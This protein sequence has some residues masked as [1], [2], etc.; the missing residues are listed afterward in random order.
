M[1]LA[2]SSLFSKLLHFKDVLSGSAWESLSVK[3]PTLCFDSGHDLTVP[4]SGSVLT[5]WSPSAILSLPLPCLC[6]L[7]LSQNK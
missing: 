7:S 5:V 3:R 6:V 4:K 1:L 2:D